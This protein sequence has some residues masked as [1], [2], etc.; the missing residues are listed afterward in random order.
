MLRSIYIRFNLRSIIL[1]TLYYLFDI[2]KNFDITSIVRYFISNKKNVIILRITF[3][4]QIFK[5]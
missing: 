2:K 4:L 1:S 3:I 5:I